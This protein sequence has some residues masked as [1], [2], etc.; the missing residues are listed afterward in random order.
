M[1]LKI[2]VLALA[3]VS[4]A[5]LLANSVATEAFCARDLSST[6][7][8]LRQTLARLNEGRSSPIPQ[9]CETFRHHVQVMQQAAVVF[10]RLSLI[11]I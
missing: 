3:L 7:A 1:R 9:R 8:K 10:G 11:H 2:V 4:P 6:Q 5:P